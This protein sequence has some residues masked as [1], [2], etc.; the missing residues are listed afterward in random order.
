M[1]LVQPSDPSS[2][3]RQGSDRHLLTAQ[4]RSFVGD[5]LPSVNGWL[6]DEAAYLTI[7]LGRLMAEEGETGG[8]FEIGVFEGKYLSALHYATR[9]IGSRVVGLDVFLWSSAQ[10]VDDHLKRLFPASNRHRLITGDS[11]RLTKYEILGWFDG[12]GISLISIDGDH[13]A[14][15]AFN[16]LLLAESIISRGGVVVCDDLL[17]P[18]AIG[19]SEGFY[20]FFA[21]RPD[22]RLRPF[23]Y[24]GNKMFLSDVDRHDFYLDAARRFPDAAPNLPV[25]EAYR[26]K[27]AKGVHW[28]EPDLLS[29]KVLV[30]A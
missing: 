11:K 26:G 3:P 18:A 14:D 21:R 2:A 13:S 6:L 28:V 17:N 12:E 15:G 9:D 29:T 19:V 22:T 24:T 20:R 8:V 7:F 27:R 10:T 16:D 30:I 5:E 4:D 25:I 1:L 23:V